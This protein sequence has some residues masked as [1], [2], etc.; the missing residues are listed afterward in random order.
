MQ[1]TAFCS[2]C[3]WRNGNAIY[4]LTDYGIQQV[5]ETALPYLKNGDYYGAFD[6]FLDALPTYKDPLDG[7]DPEK[8]PFMFTSGSRIPNA[9]H[10]RLHG[11]PANRSLRPVPT[12]DMNNEDCEALG[13]KDGD[14]VTISTL[15]GSVTVNVH[16]T[17]TVPEGLVNLYHGYSEADANSLLDEN[18][19][20]PYSGFPAYRST[21]CAVKKEG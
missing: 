11:V 4:A 3:P 6:A 13:V 5:G 20:D 12:A 8:Y 21:R 10:S 9:I 14:R 2:F 15:R 16:P 17:H 18:H 7:A 19:L 1:T